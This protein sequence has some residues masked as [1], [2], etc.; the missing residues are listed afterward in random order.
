M[1]LPNGDTSNGNPLEIWDCNNIGHNQNWAFMSDTIRSGA[2]FGKCL[3]FGDMKKGTQVQIWDCT[4]KDNQHVEYS[5][6]NQILKT[7]HSLCIEVQNGDTKNGNRLVLEDCTSYP[8]SSSSSR[9]KQT[10]NE[11]PSSSLMN[12]L[13]V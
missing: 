9:A 7:K 13:T 8:W 4:G 5:S 2:N 10:W 6:W 1:D 11:P 3:D 12:S